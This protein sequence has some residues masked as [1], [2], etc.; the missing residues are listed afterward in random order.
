ML[1]RFNLLLIVTCSMILSGCTAA[2][3]QTNDSTQTPQFTTENEGIH[4]DVP[5]TDQ[6]NST[7][8]LDIIQLQGCSLCLPTDDLP[9]A[10]ENVGKLVNEW[11]RLKSDLLV[12]T[13]SYLNKES[14]IEIEGDIY[15]ILDKPYTDGW[16][17]Y[18]NWAM[19]I[20]TDEYVSNVFTPTYLEKMQLFCEKEGKL[21]RK[22]ADGVTIGNDMDTLQ[23]W[24]DIGDVYYALVKTTS[25]ETNNFRLFQLIFHS[26]Y[27][28]QFK[29]TTMIELTMDFV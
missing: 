2:A 10:Y 25:E 14:S 26:Q 9:F 3:T 16:E 1:K 27:P 11:S 23:I 17:Y 20:F 21:Y 6:S 22:E 24:H 19:E 13:A 8:E 29:I 12:D 28:Y 18:E 5:V 7:A 15:Y 4:A